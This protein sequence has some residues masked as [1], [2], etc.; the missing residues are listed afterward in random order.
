MALQLGAAGGAQ[1]TLVW[2]EAGRA[3][4]EHREERFEVTAVAIDPGGGGWAA[5]AGRVVMRE[6]AGERARWV[7]VWQDSPSSPPVVSLF[8]DVGYVVGMTADGSV[9][10]GRREQLARA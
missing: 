9:V 3:A 4:V 7:T 6:V 8:A 10:E 5:G 1:G 2:V